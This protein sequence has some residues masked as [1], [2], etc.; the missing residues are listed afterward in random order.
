MAV[1]VNQRHH[2]N[3]ETNLTEQEKKYRQQLEEEMR[4][5]QRIE[6]YLKKHYQDLAGKVDYWMTKHEQDLEMKTRDLHDL[7]VSTI[8]GRHN[9]L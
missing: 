9:W 4:V 3:A 8:T 6:D 5:S 2:S 7:K 1:E